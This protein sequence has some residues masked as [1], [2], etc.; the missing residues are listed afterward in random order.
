MWCVWSLVD[1]HLYAVGGG[2]ESSDAQVVLLCS[3]LTDSSQIRQR[4]RKSLSR[5]MVLQLSME[6]DG[7]ISATRPRCS[8]KKKA[9]RKH[10]AQVPRCGLSGRHVSGIGPFSSCGVHRRQCR[11]SSRNSA[12]YQPEAW[13]SMEHLS[14]QVSARGKHTCLGR[15]MIQ[16]ANRLIPHVKSQQPR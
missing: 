14:V 5:Q 6:A 3:A 13:P 16:N 12:C 4:L 1:D 10:K 2:G 11:D 9:H 15:E 8:I 7:A